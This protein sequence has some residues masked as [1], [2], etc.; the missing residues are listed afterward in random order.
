MSIVNSLL[1]DLE[2]QGSSSLKRE[3]RLLNENTSA[4]G[5]PIVWKSASQPEKYERARIDRVFN[6]RRPKRYPVAVVEAES[7]EHV[8]EAV[9]LAKSKG[10]RVSIRSGGHSWAAWSVRDSAVL[11]DLGNLKEIDLDESTGIV[12]VSPSTTGRM[13]N[14]FLRGKGRLFPG[15]HC[16]DVGLGGFLLQGGM[17]WVCR[18]SLILA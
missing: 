2:C 15:G 12:K 13:L 14:G 3:E 18:V 11:I 8:A 6:N 7:T 17:G 1:T 16:P 10:Y 9:R 4:Q 5:L